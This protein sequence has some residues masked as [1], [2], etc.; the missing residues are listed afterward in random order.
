[1]PK[2]SIDKRTPRARTRSTTLIDRLRV[3]HQHALGDL[4][5]QVRRARRPDRSMHLRDVVRRGRAARAGGPRGSPRRRTAA[6]CSTCQRAASCGGRF[7]DP[8]HRARR[9]G[10]SPPR[11][12]RTRR[13]ASARARGAATAPAL[14]RRRSGRRASDTTGWK[15]SSSSPRSSARCRSFSVAWRDHGAG[16]HRLVEHLGAAATRFLGVVHRGVGVAEQLLGAF[17]AASRA[18]CRRWRSRRS[19][20]A[21]DERL[22]DGRRGAARRS[23]SRDRARS[24]S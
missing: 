3:V 14:R 13:A 19:R 24:R 10:R 5:A 21:D 18:R 2:S 4:E 15:N 23:R 7:E 8:A 6:S 12:A 22:G 17:L 20:A 16:A 9:R 1:M 11:A